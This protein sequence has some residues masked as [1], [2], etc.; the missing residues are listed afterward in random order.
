MR[1]RP[2]RRIA[3]P[4]AVLL[5]SALFAMA[6][7]TGADAETLRVDGV[8]RSYSLQAPARLPAPL[9]VVLHGNLQRGADMRTRTSWPEVARREGFAVVFP[10]GLDRA[11]ADLRAPGERGGT[12]PPRGTDD[13][14][15]IATLV[16]RLVR[17]GIADPHRVYVTGVS[18]GGA[19]TQTL[20]CVRPDLFAA[21]A[22]VIMAMTERMAAACRPSQRI[23]MLLMQ[24]TADPLIPYAGARGQRRFGVSGLY[25]AADTLRFWRRIDGCEP[26]DA[27]RT[28]LPDRVRD[29]GSTVARIASRCPADGEVLFYRVDGGGHRMPGIHA[30]ARASWL[31]DRLLGRQNGDLDAPQAIWE[32]LRHHSRL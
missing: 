17:A 29:D 8:S 3:M 32:F 2:I 5:L 12:A 27:G 26:G 24:G 20:A 9:V 23:P 13:V 14:K 10:D 21:A 11:W 15:F 28:A 18:N 1:H 30:D 31:V 22:S 7:A 25:S 19:M 4:R 6:C 16:D